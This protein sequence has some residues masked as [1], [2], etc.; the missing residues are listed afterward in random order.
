MLE[1]TT[2]KVQT[3]TIF[4]DG[5]SHEARIGIARNND[6]YTGRYGKNKMRPRIY[7]S[8]ANETVLE[9]LQNRTTRPTKTYKAIAQRVLQSLGLESDYKLSWSQ[10]AGCDCP[11]SPG[12]I[13][14]P[15][16]KWWGGP[17]AGLNIF[18][19]LDASELKNNGTSRDITTI[20]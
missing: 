7:I 15:N 12:L 10:Y 8:I 14:V 3:Q 17:L 16:D 6:A 4:V 1:I 18:I 5:Q 11:C 20:I 2:S 19:Q 13:G 9:N